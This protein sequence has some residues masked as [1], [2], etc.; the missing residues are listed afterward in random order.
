MNRSLSK[1]PRLLRWRYLR[2]VACSAMIPALWACNSRRLAIPD[3]APA[4]IDTRQFKQTVNHKLDLLF[5]VD[6]SSSMTPLQTKMQKQLP[7]FMAALA[8][9]TT[10][11]L[12][13]LHVAVVSSSYGG[14]AWG[15]VNQCLSAVNHADTL[16]DDQG[17]FLQGAIGR[18]DSPC[19]MLHAG[20]KYLANGDG[21]AAH[22]AN[23][24]GDIGTAFS[25]IALL[26]DKGCGFESQFESV[27]YGLYKGTLPF[28]SGDGQD[29]DNG[30]FIRPDAVLAIVMVTN[31]DD[32]SVSGDS[33]L[34]DPSVNTVADKSGLGALQSYRCNEFG[35][36]CDGQPPPHDPPGS[37]VTLKNCVSAEEMGKTDDAIVYPDGPLKGQPDKTHGHLWPTVAEFTAYIKQ[38]KPNNPDDILVAAIAGPVA[39][40]QGNSLYRVHGEANS[41]AGGE[42]DPVVDHSCTQATSDSTMPEYAD[43]AVRISQWVQSFNTPGGSQNGVFYPICANDFSAAM[44]GIAMKIN[45]KLGA[46]C[47]STHIAP[48]AKDPNKHN[49]QVSQKITEASGKVSTVKLPECDPGN[50]NAPCFQLTNNPAKCPDPNAQTL[51]KVCNDPSCTAVQGSTDSKDAN[52]ACSVG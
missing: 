13:D 15:N 12:P 28:G 19:K 50:G 9:P 6:D 48:D 52:I 39:D 47:V 2:W 23:F 33:L 35:H 16:G 8:D 25:C 24:D 40:A 17:R 10:M 38:Y 27:Y 22:P 26:G 44:R 37:T 42:I 5:M 30:G 49:C 43:P 51:F 11:Q 41:S 1:V 14:G 4:V 31:E 29:P 7:A 46:S 32:C 18:M 3:P 34:L 21:T 45:Q 20:E 36:L